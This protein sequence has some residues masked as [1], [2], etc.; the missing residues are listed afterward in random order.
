MT[1]QIKKGLIGGVLVGTSAFAGVFSYYL[2]KK[3][4]FG[5]EKENKKPLKLVF[6]MTDNEFSLTLYNPTDIY[7]PSNTIMVHSF[8]SIGKKYPFNNLTEDEHATIVRCVATKEALKQCN[9]QLPEVVTIGY[10][11]SNGGY[12]DINVG[13]TDSNGVYWKYNTLRN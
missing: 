12:A 3:Y 6:N 5:K 9:K 13:Y 1:T 8:S 11:D 2:W 7:N 10:S 4:C